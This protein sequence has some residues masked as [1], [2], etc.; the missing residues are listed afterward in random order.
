MQLVP[1]YSVGGIKMRSNPT[2]T[3]A[4]FPALTHF[5]GADHGGAAQVRESS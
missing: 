1:P 4:S 3:S 2:L 5:A